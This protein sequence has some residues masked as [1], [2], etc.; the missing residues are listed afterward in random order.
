LLRPLN[1]PGLRC[2]AGFAEL[3]KRLEDYAPVPLEFFI[4]VQRSALSARRPHLDPFNQ[5]VNTSCEA[6]KFAISA[7][8]GFRRGLV[9]HQQTVLLELVC[10][11][12][13]QR[14]NVFGILPGQNH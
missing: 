12:P 5:A 7:L 11:D 13:I 9:E 6:H 14:W 10:N 1:V 2:A 4:P 3:L 8:R